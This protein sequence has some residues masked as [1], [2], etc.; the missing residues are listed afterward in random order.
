MRLRG[1]LTSTAALGLAVL[2]AA[3]VAI[4]TSVNHARAID[5][6]TIRIP[7]TEIMFAPA[8][9][10]DMP[11]MTARQAW[12]RFSRGDRSTA[13][14]AGTT[15]KLRL[16]TVPIGPY[17]GRECDGHPVRA[18]IAY[19]ALDQLAYGYSWLAFP[20]RHLKNRNWIFLDANTGH[21]IIGTVS[22]EPGSRATLPAG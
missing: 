21:M 13:I 22:R 5:A 3:A 6:N 17:C 7:G 1:P 10:G 2:A 11:N 12:A 20:H 9:A 18:G 19:T 8:P 16:L 14:A 4:W 15:V